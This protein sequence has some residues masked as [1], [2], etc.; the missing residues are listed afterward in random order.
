MLGATDHLL[1]QR[2][3]LEYRPASWWFCPRDRRIDLLLDHGLALAGGIV[4]RS[5]GFPQTPELR[6]PPKFPYVR[7][8]FNAWGDYV[9]H[10]GSP[11]RLEQAPP[12]S[13]L[14]TPTHVPAFSPRLRERL[15]GFVQLCHERGAR[16]CYTFP[17]RPESHWPAQRAAIDRVVSEL[18]A[19][20]GLELLDQP[21]DHVYEIGLFS[22]TP[23]HLTEE[24]GRRRSLK[25]AARLK[26]RQEPGPSIARSR[27]FARRRP[28]PPGRARRRRNRGRTGV[29]GGWHRR[30]PRPGHSGT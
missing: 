24:G 14:R 28:S 17:P 9:L 27:R 21:A 2:Q 22:D 8:G 7:D 20:A 10:H 12:D 19:L 5:I 6:E 4:R 18:R 23:D 16:V 29:A 11:F 1:H 13:P 25:V 15:E 26:R 3:L 30:I